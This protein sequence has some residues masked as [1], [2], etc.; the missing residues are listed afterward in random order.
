MEIIPAIIPESYEDLRKKLTLVKGMVDCVQIDITDGIFVPSKSWPINDEIYGSRIHVELPFCDVCNFEL[1]LMIKNPEEKISDWVDTQ[2]NRIVFHIE[3]TKKIDEIIEKLKGK[4]KVG[5]AF[6]INT[7]DELYDNIISKVD[8][9]QLMGIEKI[10][11]QG[12]PFSSRVF[13][14]I[15]NLRKRFPDIVIS[16]DGGVNLENAKCLLDAGANRLV[17]GSAIFESDNIKQAIENF[18]KIIK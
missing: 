7:Q 12:Q 14:K 3:S 8:F 11:S 5:V 2:A 9:V 17:A 1:D 4:V 18:K 13:D 10:G 15:K 16:V 6:N